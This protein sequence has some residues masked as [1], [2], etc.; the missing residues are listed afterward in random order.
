MHI[1][2]VSRAPAIALAPW[3]ERLW[4]SRSPETPH[5]AREI[6]LPTGLTHLVWRLHGPPLEI[7]GSVGDSSGAVYREAVLGGPRTGFYRKAVGA[8]AMWPKRQPQPRSEP[9]P[10]QLYTLTCSGSPMQL[11]RVDP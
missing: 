5:C 2:P 1:V 3:V 4:L 7:F 8:Q 9:S 6:V 11:T 10:L